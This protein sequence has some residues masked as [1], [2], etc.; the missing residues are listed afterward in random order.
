MFLRKSKSKQEELNRGN[1]QSGDGEILAS[2]AGLVAPDDR[3]A[4]PP[5]Q[6]SV[7]IGEKW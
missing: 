7:G 3:L 5:G 6:I 4:P 2:L 1:E